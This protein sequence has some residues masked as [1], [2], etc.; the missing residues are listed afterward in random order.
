MSRLLEYLKLIPQALSKPDKIIEGW[1]NDIKLRNGELPDAEVA[2][3]IRRR[4]ICEECPFTSSNAVANP[5]MGY[6]TARLDEHCIL[7]GCPRDKK[8]AALSENCGAEVFNQSNPKQKPIE[9][10]WTA[11]KP[12][13]NE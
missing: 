7:C 2:E 1:V 4:L 5:A 11:Y 13:N 9:L 8:T 10:R 3:I 12:T 6:R